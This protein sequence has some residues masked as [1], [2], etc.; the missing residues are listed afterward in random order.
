MSEVKQLPQI[1]VC[2]RCSGTGLTGIRNCPVCHGYGWG[3][4]YGRLFLYWGRRVDAFFIAVSRIKSVIDFLLNAAALLAGLGGLA[5]LALLARTIDPQE[6]LT[7]AFWQAPHRNL[8]G[9]WFGAICLCFL[10]YRRVVAASRREFVR[11]RAYEAPRKGGMPEQSPAGDFWQSMHKVPRR[12]RIDVSRAFGSETLKAVDKAYLL[13][14]KL[15]QAGVEPTHFFATLLSTVKIAV[16]FGRLGLR[17]E[18]FQD[19]LSRLVIQSSAAASDGTALSDRAR[20]VL[21]GSYVEAYEQKQPVVEVTELF[22]AAIRADDRLQELL[23]DLD[24]DSQKVENVVSWIRVQDL[25]RRRYS[26]FSSAA[27]LKPKTT[28]DRSMTAVATPYLDRI[29][30][31]LTIAAG[32]GHFAPVIGRD[33]EFEAVFR[34]IE[35]GRRSVILVGEP[36]TGKG[37]II[38]GIAQ[39]MV[40]EDVPKILQDKRLVSL[41]IAQLISGAS[42]AE[43]QERLLNALYEV[44]RAGNIVLIVP[45]AAGMVGISAGTGESLDLSQVFAT[46]LSRGYFFAIC[47]ATPREYTGTLESTPLGRALVKVDIPEVEP[48]EAIRILEA[49]AGGIE[50]ANGV[51]FSYDAVDAAVRLTDRYMHEQFLPEKAILIA[52]EAATSVRNKKGENSTVSKDDVAEVVAEKTNIPLKTLTA[53]ES[54]KLLELEQRMHGRIVGQDQAVRAVAAA[55]RRARAELREQ[56]RPIAN[57]LFLGPTGVGK[58]ELAKTLADAY[59]GSEDLMIR[60]DMSEYQDKASLYKLIGEPAGAQAGGILSEAIRKQP[61]TLLLLD[62]VE[63]AHPDI[64]TVFLQVMDDGRL[65]DNVG[66]TI[67]FTNVI[68]IATSNAGAQFIQDEIKKK[69]PIPQIKEQLVSTQLRQYY[70]PEFLNRFDDIIVFT[71]LG[72]EEI[73]QIAR[74]MLTKVAKRLEAKG[75]IFEAT[76]EAV[77]ELAK[78]GYDPIF[79]ARP[80]RR[81]I[82]DRVDNVIADALLQGKLGRRDKLIFETGG[83]I[84]VEKAARL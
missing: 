40:E 17:Y 76:E 15:K 19:K 80:L 11:Q 5:L 6:A 7:T 43:A 14:R 23:F 44:A 1:N 39:R 68:L 78:A 81:A 48:N 37:A 42:A 59:F 67:D 9:F 25:L 13:A 70:R 54:H 71:P 31:D 12:S 56:S 41:N 33:R 8:L 55:M 73:V 35:G 84:R 77:R 64:L 26:R 16:I 4:I 52:K 3:L 60:L 34:A 32:Y 75:V 63:K 69:T 2:A 53:E 22:V 72:E 45:D 83:K 28:M 50:Y 65:T 29:S 46:E 66:R 62:E 18:K 49:K 30:R 79:G 21:L 24:A 58:T 10:Y 61:F 51:Y 74:L 82:Q 36:G 57:F 47:T 27:K 38:E 20:T